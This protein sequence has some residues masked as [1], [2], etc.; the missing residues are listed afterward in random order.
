MINLKAVARK[1]SSYPNILRLAVLVIIIWYMILASVSYVT[2]KDETGK[3]DY[4]TQNLPITGFTIAIQI[5]F[6][7]NALSSY[8]VQILCAFEIIE[9]L[10]FFK[11]K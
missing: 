1:K 3:K 4:I 2:Y 5:L 11:N 6:C 8:P 7:L 9:D 10:E